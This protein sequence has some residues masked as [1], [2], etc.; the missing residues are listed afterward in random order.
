MQTVNISSIL[1]N[2]KELKNLFDNNW[3]QNFVYNKLLIDF[4]VLQILIWD[5][6]DA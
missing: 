3:K 4:F 2:F 6:E 5:D 1:L